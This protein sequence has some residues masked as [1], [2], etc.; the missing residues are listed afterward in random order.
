VGRASPSGEIDYLGYQAPKKSRAGLFAGVVAALALVVVS[1]FLWS[2]RGG[3]GSQVTDAAVPGASVAS[4]ADSAAIQSS[5]GAAPESSVVALLPTVDSQAIRDSIRRVARAEAAKKAAAKKD[6]MKSVQVVTASPLTKARGAAAAMLSDESARKEFAK[7][8]TH[9]GGVLG[10]KR[11]GDLQTQIDAL[12]PFLRRASMSYE[13]FKIL[14]QGTGVNMF[15]EYGR[16][17]PD[18]LQRFAS[19]N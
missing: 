5:A 4:I 3:D 15:D 19:G 7:G 13:H 8:A 2:Q 17:L 10:T 16:M 14:V 11:T 18:A 12:Q 1:G 6:S 9:M